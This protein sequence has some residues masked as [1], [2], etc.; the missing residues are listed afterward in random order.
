MFESIKLKKRQKELEIIKKEIIKAKNELE[1]IKQ[2]LEEKCEKIDIS[3]IYVFSY[4]GI[5]YLVYINKVDSV[6]NEVI[7]IFNNQIIFH[8]FKH[9]I[10]GRQRINMEY[11]ER[12]N[13][14]DTYATLVPI[15]ENNPDL[16][17]YVDR[18]VPSYVLQK[19]LYKLNNLDIRS[20]LKSKLN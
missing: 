15:I 1:A 10:E 17:I 14:K 13:G 3:N 11:K 20:Y 12:F 4:G 19:Y 16:L 6:Y 7:D 9:D 18:Q 8:Y 2:L 5:S